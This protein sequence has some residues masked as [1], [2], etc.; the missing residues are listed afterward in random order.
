MLIVYSN[1]AMVMREFQFPQA[2]LE[3]QD[4]NSD[5]S[6]ISKIACCSVVPSK[7]FFDHI[8]SFKA[9]VRPRY[10]KCVKNNIIIES[11]HFRGDLKVS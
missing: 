2:K 7:Y 1:N 4:T 10:G 3:Y 9:A 6:P 5:T 8:Y 11:S